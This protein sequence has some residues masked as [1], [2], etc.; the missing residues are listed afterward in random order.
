MTGSNVDHMDVGAYALGVLSDW[1]ATQ[2]EAH[3]AG[4]DV[5][6]RELEE[7]TLVSSL[8]S[9]VDGDSLDAVEHYDRDGR[10]LDRMLNVVSLERRRARTRRVLSAAAA[11]V[12]VVAGIAFGIIGLS[13]FSGAGSSGTGN[14]A[15]PKPTGSV[16]IREVPPLTPPQRFQATDKVSGADA[17]VT[18][19]GRRW[20]SEVQLKLTRVNGPLVCQLIAVGKDEQT[21]VAMTWTV[22][23]SGYG[24]MAQPDPLIVGGSASIKPADLDHF[25]VRAIEG[26]VERNPI[27][28]IPVNG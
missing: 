22:E 14:Q 2:F 11:I 26:K 19:T 28:T 21:A 23:K 3:L 24:N 13:P 1:E 7:L 5:C 12:V 9:H 25:E 6:A 4:C 16:G 17:E 20:G 18:V 8:L 10:Q 27:V 15:R